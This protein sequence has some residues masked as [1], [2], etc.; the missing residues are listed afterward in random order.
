MINK[1][2]IEFIKFLSKEDTKTLSQKTLKAVEE[3]GELSRV[4]LPYDSAFATNHRFI[5]KDDI[6]EEIIDTYLS[7]ISIAY[8]LDFSDEDIEEMIGEKTVKWANLINREK[9]I[10][11]PM[12]YEL[13]VTIERPKNINSFKDAC[14]FLKV[15]PII[16]DIKN[17]I[18][19]TIQ[20]DIMTSSRFFGNNKEAYEEIKKISNYLYKNNFKVIREKIETVIYHPS[21]PKELNEKILHK[22]QYFEA[23][24]DIITTNDT[25][26]VLQEICKIN[27]S[28]ISININKKI[29]ETEFISM[30]TFRENN[31]NR[32]SF[33]NSVNKLIKDLNN[34][35]FNIK[36]K[37]M[38]FAV[39][40]TNE[41]HDDKWLN[42]I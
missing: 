5:D 30:V 36:N 32:K 38:E 37:V 15:K 2:L 20:N 4:I 11:W 10:K 19:E 6:L 12:P 16:L 17:N 25:I 18:G 21:A 9:D 34:N 28:R 41:Y 29:S 42:I 33:E 40:D 23:H 22:H 14:S 3:L 35:K 8:T 13:H 1:N 7:I 39:Y 31:S 27:N 24:I 26:K